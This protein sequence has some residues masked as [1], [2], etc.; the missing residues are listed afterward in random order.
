MF[1]N[2]FLRGYNRDNEFYNTFLRSIMHF[3]SYSQ[4]CNGMTYLD[5][6]QAQSNSKVEENLL[7]DFRSVP[8]FGS[9]KKV[10]HKLA[11]CISIDSNFSF[12]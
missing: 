3:N 12:L 4:K 11:A 5:Y 9:E 6:K 8:N 1:C 2:A 10:C 7:Q